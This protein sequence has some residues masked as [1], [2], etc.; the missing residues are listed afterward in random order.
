MPKAA[1]GAH[2]LMTIKSVLPALSRV[3]SHAQ[4]VPQ[5]RASPSPVMADGGSISNMDYH[6]GDH[7][8]HLKPVFSAL[9]ASAHSLGPIEHSLQRKITLD[10]H[11]LFLFPRGARLIL[12]DQ[13]CAFFLPHSCTSLQW[14]PNLPLMT[15]IGS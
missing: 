15:L 6:P 1:T 12:Q 8:S 3:I 14:R 11:T 2:S 9:G 13:V 4:L 5:C 10:P 7:A